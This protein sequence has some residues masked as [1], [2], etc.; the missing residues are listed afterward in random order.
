M[1]IPLG[2]NCYHFICNQPAPKCLA[3]PKC[4]WLKVSHF[5]DK[6]GKSDDNKHVQAWWR[7]VYA[8]ELILFV[9]PLSKFWGWLRGETHWHAQNRPSC[10]P[11]YGKSPP[12][13]RFTRYTNTCI[14]WAHFKRVLNPSTCLFCRLGCHPFSY[15][16]S[17]KSLT[18][19]L[20]IRHPFCITVGP[21]LRSALL[22]GKVDKCYLKF[23]P[24]EGFF[25]ST[26]L[27][28]HSEYNIMTP[29]V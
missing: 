6:L 15:L 26:V 16:A 29:R 2:S 8:I 9:N 1:S 21:Y 19:Q 24:L 11:D 22:I 3:V 18:M 27:Q 17:S 23:Y 14:V 7:E 25:F 13:R 10:L 5:V 4:K 12:F 28:G 20:T